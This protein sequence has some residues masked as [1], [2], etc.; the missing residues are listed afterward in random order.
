M[1][2]TA[3]AIFN[4]HQISVVARVTLKTG[5]TMKSSQQ[6]TGGNIF[7]DPEWDD[8]VDSKTN[9]VLVAGFLAISFTL[10]LTSDILEGATALLTKSI[11]KKRNKNVR[12]SSDLY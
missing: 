9:R 5:T 1:S 12:S 4:E 7:E 11:F 6:R 3:R 10:M 8:E 2:S